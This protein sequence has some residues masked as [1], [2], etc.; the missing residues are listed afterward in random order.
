MSRCPFADWQPIAAN[1]SQPTIKPVGLVLHT[2][3]SNSDALKPWSD[4]EWTFYVGEQGQL[5][6][7]MDTEVRADCQR[8]GNSWVRNGVRYGFLSVETWDGAGVVWDGK[9]TAKCPRWTDAQVKTLARLGAWLHAEHGIELIKATAPQGKGI[10]YHA[11]FTSSSF[12]RWNSNHACPAAARISQFPSVLKA[13]QD[14]ANPP[15]EDMQADER[16]WLKDVHSA[17]TGIGSLREQNDDGSRT[18][19]SAGYYLAHADRNAYDSKA[20]LQQQVVPALVAEAQRDAIQAAV[21][22][23]VESAVTAIARD[24]IVTIEQLEDLAR[25]TANLT[26]IELIG[27]RTQEPAQ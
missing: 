11:Q 1:A 19:H 2:A 26:T 16:Q 5:T 25:R 7:Y 15:E 17:V 18:L 23:A 27:E 8:D 24:G 14:A 21:V 9:N 10:G 4:I 22:R 6:Q 13:M 12:P 20:I 3:V